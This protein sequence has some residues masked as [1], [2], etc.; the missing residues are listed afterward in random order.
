MWYG[1]C[2]YA[3]LMLL[4]RIFGDSMNIHGFSGL[5]W[6]LGSLVSIVAAGAGVLLAGTLLVLRAQLRSLRNVLSVL[7][8]ALVI[9]FLAYGTF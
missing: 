9:G 8:G 3:V 5:F 4:A 6:L 2:T 1:G 7:L